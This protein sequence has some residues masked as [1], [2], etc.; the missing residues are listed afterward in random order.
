MSRTGVRIPLVAQKHKEII[1]I[2][3]INITKN[4]IDAANLLISENGQYSYCPIR[5]ALNNQTDYACWF[6][7]PEKDGNVAVESVK[8][9]RVRLPNIVNEFLSKWEENENPEPF[10][11]D[12]EYEGVLE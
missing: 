8:K 7:F 11:F 6:I 10:E 5:L 9:I 12:F 4:Y 2:D 3:R 1:M